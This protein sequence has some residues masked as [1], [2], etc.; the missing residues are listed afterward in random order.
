MEDVE[1][2]VLASC[3]LM[4]RAERSF[5]RETQRA[6]PLFPNLDVAT[7]HAEAVESTIQN[8]HYVGVVFLLEVSGR[9]EIHSMGDSREKNDKDGVPVAAE[10]KDT[11][12]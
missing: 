1:S 10:N 12:N 4:D 5:M 3:R 7:H 11:S 8:I 6:L 9:V 2:I